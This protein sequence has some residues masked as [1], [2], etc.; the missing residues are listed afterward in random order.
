MRRI[1][2]VILCAAFL[3]IAFSSRSKPGV[4]L[5]PV[6]PF[7][8][9][10]P[11]AAVPE[12]A[13]TV[14]TAPRPTEAVVQTVTAPPRV[15]LQMANRMFPPLITDRS[16]FEALQ[17][18]VGR[19]RDELV[20]TLELSGQLKLINTGTPAFVLER[21]EDSR[22]L[23]LT[24]GKYAKAEGWVEERYI[25][26]AP[27]SSIVE[28]AQREHLAEVVKKRQRRAGASGDLSPLMVPIPGFDV[29]AT[30]MGF[31]GGNTGG[32]MGVGGMNMGSHL[33][34]AMTLRG[35]PCQR[36][37]SGFGYC[38]DHR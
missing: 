34:G 19:E 31:G 9:V 5:P 3:W 35:F 16:S 21:W 2:G 36:I 38:Y 33:C 10:V 30:S 17:K 32:Q 14:A 29:S 18:A 23:L 15:F 25:R 24:G 8:A 7:P 20:R 37:V 13:K 1:V 11:G 22:L 28:L 12:S 26:D 6:Q 4:P 27:D